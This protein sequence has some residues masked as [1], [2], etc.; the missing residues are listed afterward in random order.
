M[1]AVDG[2]NREFWHVLVKS[3]LLDRLEEM[4]MKGLFA[5]LF[6]AL[7]AF[8]VLSSCGQN[9]NE[10]ELYNKWEQKYRTEW[11]ESAESEGYEKGYEDGLKDGEAKAELKYEEEQQEEIENKENVEQKNE[12][13]QNTIQEYGEEYGCLVWNVSNE[14]DLTIDLQKSAIGN[15]YIVRAYP[16]DLFLNSDSIMMKAEG[17]DYPDLFYLKIPNDLE[18]EV[19]ES[20]YEDCALII[21]VESVAPLDMMNNYIEY[22]DSMGEEV[23][24]VGD[25]T[26][27]YELWTGY[28]LIN[29]TCEKIIP[30]DK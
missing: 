7:S 13:I 3:E 2:N 27:E 9:V 12:T 30:L 6:V 24:L 23:V 17:L 10:N 8:V 26:I 20:N 5:K 28:R 21:T 19:R 29:G 16:T 15:R 11:E 18:D 4:H 1:R 25:A 14:F 22:G